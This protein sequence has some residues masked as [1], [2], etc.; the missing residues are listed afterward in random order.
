MTA[1][2]QIMAAVMIAVPFTLN[3]QWLH[4]PTPGIPRTPDGRPNL[5]ASAPRTPQGKPD[6]SG[7]W[8]L[9]AFGKF[10]VNL[11]A[12][13]TEVPLR[14]SAAALYNHRLETFGAEDPATRCLPSGI[15]RIYADPLPLKI[16]Q[17][18]QLI[19]MLHEAMSYRQIFLDGRELPQDPRP[20]WMGYSVG[21]W[22]G[23][24]LVVTSAGFNERAWLDANGHPLSDAMRL[25]ESFQRLDVGRLELQITIDDPK[26][27]AKPLTVTLTLELIADT[28]LLEFV[29]LENEQDLRH[30]V[31]K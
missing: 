21:R 19:V 8:R 12:D 29:C 20:A 15:P 3:A 31:M 1:N 13:L 14:S 25:T 18:P 2:L 6:L 10:H 23:D 11:T 30:Q 27:Y 22:E 28:E 4:Q 16:V 26:T 17:L 7:I 5:A 9:R 24:T